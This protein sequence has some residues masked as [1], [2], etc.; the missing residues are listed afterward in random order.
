MRALE[1][2]AGMARPTENAILRGT[3]AKEQNF[4]GQ[5]YLRYYHTPFTHP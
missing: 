4:S 2:K 3:A 1:V 5:H